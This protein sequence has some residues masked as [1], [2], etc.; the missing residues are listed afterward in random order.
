[1]SR[2]EEADVTAAILSAP[3]W[4]R[5]GLTMPDPGLRERAAGELARAVLAGIGVELQSVDLNQLT[6]P[7]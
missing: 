6:L 3:G 7:I 4:A 5:V 2:I 1:M